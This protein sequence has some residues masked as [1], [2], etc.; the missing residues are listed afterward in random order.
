MENL[1]KVQEM[2]NSIKE[3]I[4]KHNMSIKEMKQLNRMVHLKL[5]SERTEIPNYD[6]Y[7]ELN[8]LPFVLNLFENNFQ[9]GKVAD[10]NC[11]YKML[12][13]VREEYFNGE[14]NNNRYGKFLN[15]VNDKNI[16]TLDDFKNITLPMILNM[17][18]YTHSLSYKEKKQFRN[19][20]LKY[21][22]FLFANDLIDTIERRMSKTGDSLMKFVI[23]DSILHLRSDDVTFLYKKN[24]PMSDT[25]YT[26]KEIVFE[27]IDM[28]FLDH[29]E[30]FQ[31][32][33]DS[34]MYGL[35]EGFENTTVEYLCTY[36]GYNEDF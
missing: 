14:L 19:I 9:M 8:E 16:K 1:S 28:E 29:F 24:Y 2:E 10:N 18:K 32:I 5:I 30:I 27:D 25:E 23:G 20:K 7:K 22:A 26:K 15:F 34:R 6:F 31:H 35:L 12:F 36:N 21:I 11:R 4:E 33:Q 13:S 17:G 3:L